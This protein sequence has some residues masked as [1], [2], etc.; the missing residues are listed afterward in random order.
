MWTGRSVSANESVRHYVANRRRP[1]RCPGVARRWLRRDAGPLVEPAPT[2]AAV[3]SLITQ[4]GAAG[5]SCRRGRFAVRT[6]HRHPLVAPR[7]RLRDAHRA[8]NLDGTG[9][10]ARAPRARCFSSPITPQAAA[11]PSLAGRARLL[12]SF[13]RMC[14]CSTW[15]ASM[16]SLAGRVCGLDRRWRGRLVRAPRGHKHAVPMA[17]PGHQS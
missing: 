7:T 6:G 10:A 12:A 13:W 11:A 3:E 14:P 16:P 2:R 4:C 9:Y 15:R 5:P 8:L 1:G 17:G